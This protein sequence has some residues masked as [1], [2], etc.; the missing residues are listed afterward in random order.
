MEARRLRWA[1]A[2]LGRKPGAREALA[3]L[4]NVAQMPGWV[5]TDQRTWRTG[6]AHATEVTQRAKQA[7]SITAWRS[8]RDP[9]SA[10]WVW[11]QVVPL[12]NPTD[13]GLMLPEVKD[14]L[15]ANR[16]ANV[17]LMDERDVE[18]PPFPGAA[19]V[20]A[21]EQHTTG[22]SGIGVTR[23]LAGAVGADI[24]V[25]AGSG[26]PEWNWA[27]VVE[28]ATRQAERLVAQRD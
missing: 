12:A 18:L 10:R 2:Q 22:P 17:T 8:L 1:I 15:L 4:L 27:S 20:F 25:V 23:Y 19:A 28:L 21:H 16:G 11:L 14:R 13:A 6:T 24:V 7:G 26:S 5:V 9:A 3:R